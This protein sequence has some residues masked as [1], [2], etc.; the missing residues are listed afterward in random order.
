MPVFLIPWA[1]LSFDDFQKNLVSSI[2]K[3]AL[4]TLQEFIGCDAEILAF[5]KIEGENQRYECSWR[6]ISYAQMDREDLNKQFGI[7]GRALTNVIQAIDGEN[8]GE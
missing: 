8:V 3:D 6:V 5:P 1:S 4:L 2:L 7:F